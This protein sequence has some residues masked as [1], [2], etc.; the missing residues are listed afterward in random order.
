MSILLGVDL[1]STT[2]KLVALQEDGVLL[3]VQQNKNHSSA[4][5]L[6]AMVEQ[7]M[8]DQHLERAQIER[9]LLTGVGSL[10]TFGDLLELPTDRI[11]EFKA[12]GYGAQTLS[13]NDHVIAV[14]MGTGTAFV[15]ANGD[16]LQ[17][18]GG[19]GVGGGTILGLAKLLGKGDDYQAILHEAQKGSY[20]KVDLLV[21][22]LISQHISTLPAHLTAANFGNLRKKANDADVL[23]GIINMVLQT[24]G[25]LAVFACRND[26]IKTVVFTGSL[27][28]VPQVEEVFP[29]L[30]SLYQLQLIVPPYAV[31]ATA[32]GAVVAYWKRHQ[33]PFDF[34]VEAILEPQPR[35]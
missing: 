27:T 11:D 24:I 34:R 22:D 18:I 33:H 10:K 21:E 4:M 17:H 16:D 23:A 1:G 20:T 3:A 28:T 31:Y 13:Y 30:Q 8:Q 25:M 5:A 29:V 7:F 9:I 32:I 26:E 19:S 35:S 2:T 14:S 12:I 15:R 6:P